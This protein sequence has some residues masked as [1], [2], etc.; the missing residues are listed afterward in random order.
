MSTMRTLR[1]HI[2][3]EWVESSANDCLDITNPA[4]AEP[5][6]RV[7]LSTSRDV[8]QAVAAARP[9]F[10]PWRAV[11]PVVRARHLFHFKPVLAQHF[12][13]AASIIPR[14]HGKTL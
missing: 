14:E 1:N 9:A 2:G 6:G 11:P 13:E 10:P 8:D 3:G 12:D 5:L 7:P 4:T